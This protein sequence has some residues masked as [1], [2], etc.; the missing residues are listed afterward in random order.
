MVLDDLPLFSMAAPPPPPVIK[1]TGVNKKL[2]EVFPDE[3]T[4]KDA[5]ALIYELKA[6]SQQG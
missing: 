2:A 4:P 5:L 6:L 1:D 3:L